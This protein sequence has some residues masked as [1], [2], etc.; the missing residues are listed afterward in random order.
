ML[1]LNG[2]IKKNILKEYSYDVTIHRDSWGVPHIYGQSD[3]DAAFGL[4]YAHCEDDYKTIEEVV[5]ALRGEFASVKGYKYAPIDYLVG[6]LKIW[7]T[8]N[9]KYDNEISDELKIVCNAYADGVNRYI[10]KNNIKSHIYPAKGKDIIAGFFFRTPLMFEFDWFLRELMK[11]EKPTFDKYASRTSTFS[12]YGSNTIAVAPSRSEDNYTRITTNSHQPWEG[13]VTWYEAHIN[14]NEGWNMSGGLF[15]G[16][17]LIFKGYNDSLAWSH[18]VNNPDL[19][20][21]YEL[22]INPNN[23]NQYMLDNQWIDFET[24]KLPIKVK[25]LGPIK[26]T[27]KRD[28]YWSKHG[29]V[30]KTDHGVYALRYSAFDR[31]GQVEQ[32]F[33][34]NKASNIHE[35]KKA[36]EMMEIPMFNTL[37]ADH[38]GNI[39]YIYNALIP[40]REKGYDWSKIVPGDN[41]ALI[42][43]S[44][45]SF[46][47]LPQSLNPES[48]YLQNCNSTPYEATTGKGNP[49]N[50]LPEEAGIETFQT[51][52]AFRANEL[53]GQ[54]LSISRQEFEDYKYDTFYSKKSVMK[55]ALDQFLSDIDRTD[56]QYLD[57]IK[58]LENWDLSND[59]D[60]KG[61]ALALLTFELTYD[62]SDFKYDYDKIFESF[63]KSI[64]FL[65]SNYGTI[66]IKLGEL[67]IL[68]RGDK[69]L[70]LSGAPD[71]LRAIYTK[72]V[73]DK[74]IAIAGDCFF[75]IIEWDEDGLV[76]AKSIHQYGSSTNEQASPHFSDQSVL[77]SKHQM[78]D[79]Y[80][81]FEDLKDNIKK[82]YQP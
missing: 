1:T 16:S 22:T 62:I 46:N 64:E 50:S 41:S 28:L 13:P 11:E 14:S 34:M 56:E 32:W 81:R 24:K 18:T 72:S 68:K 4:A 66:D 17:P 44:Y 61:A 33:R 77:F 58:V 63:T 76:N 60:S 9:E 8:V 21:I 57:A 40:K 6:L 73:D 30:I 49:L 15:P 48:G 38:N 27:F 37:Y 74:E 10:E 20:D 82:T 19:V 65:N 52:R 78:K 70:P 75:Q 39:Y 54:D 35:F 71:V 23:E 36:M 53:Y 47:E 80:I 7:E 5:L 45:Y 51:N 55:Y 29:P 42:W 43:D 59:M 3:K 79:S 25:L 67:Q 2:Y 69:E 12:M 26:W 31:I